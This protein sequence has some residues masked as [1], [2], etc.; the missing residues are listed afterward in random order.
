MKQ[1]PV[2]RRVDA[3][4]ELDFWEVVPSPGQSHVCLKVVFTHGISLSS[5]SPLTPIAFVS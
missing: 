4:C 3:L 1:V 5:V 2:Q